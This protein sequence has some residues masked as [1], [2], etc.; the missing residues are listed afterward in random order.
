MQEKDFFG[1]L[2][3]MLLMASD[4]NGGVV[5][6]TLA[7]LIG[8]GSPGATLPQEHLR[9]QRELVQNMPFGLAGVQGP[10]GTAVRA[11]VSVENG[12]IR[13]SV[14]HGFPPSADSGEGVLWPAGSMFELETPW[15]YNISAQSTP[16]RR[17]RPS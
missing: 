15:S 16:T 8:G 12:A 3:A 1:V 10:E 11:I 6:V 7:D 9:M 13:T 4:G 2:G 14:T 17:R 5:R